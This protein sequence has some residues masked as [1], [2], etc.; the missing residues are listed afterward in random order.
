MET[1]PLVCSGFGSEFQNAKSLG[2][3]GRHQPGTFAGQFGGDV[4]HTDFER[5]FH[6][7]EQANETYEVV[8]TGLKFRCAATEFNC[9]LRDEIGAANVVPAI[10]GWIQFFL[11]TAFDV[12]NTR[13][14]WTKKPFV[15]VG[16]E[17]NHV[18]HR[19]GKCGKS[20]DG[21]EA[22]KNSLLAEEFA[23]GVVFNPLAADEMARSECHEPGI[24]STWRITSTVRMAPRLRVLSNRTCTPLSARAI[25]G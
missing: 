1:M 9:F 19:R 25:H 16:R 15:G 3:Q 10:H 14:T 20:L 12:E 22:E 17:K 13:A 11:Q 6:G 5:E 7:A 18:F 24:L 21:V 8:R 4:V 23:D 2:L